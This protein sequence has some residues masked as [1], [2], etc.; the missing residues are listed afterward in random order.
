MFVVGRLV[1]ALAVLAVAAAITGL[2]LMLISPIVADRKPDFADAWKAMFITYI[3]QGFAGFLIAITM[4]DA[5]PNLRVGVAAVVGFLIL[6][7]CIAEQAEATLP[8]AV[9]T[10]VVMTIITML[11]F[12]VLGEWIESVTA[13]DAEALLGH[14]R[15]LMA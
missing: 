4:H 9:L 11:G 13:D 12:V 1:L 5:D 3:G 7:F 14:A 8:R 6:T 10:A 15:L 2:I